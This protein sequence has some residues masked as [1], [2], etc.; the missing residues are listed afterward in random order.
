[1]T[2]ARGTGAAAP[3]VT[4]SRMKEC[5]HP[6]PGPGP[7]K[8]KY[9]GLKR[10]AVGVRSTPLR[11]GGATPHAAILY[12]VK[13][14]TWVFEMKSHEELADGIGKEDYLWVEPAIPPERLMLVVRRLKLVYGAHKQKKVPYG[15]RYETSA[16]DENGGFRLGTGEIGFTCATIVAAIFAAERLRLI[17]PTQWPAPDGFDQD[18][19]RK[20]IDSIRA[21]FPDHAK[22]LDRDITAPRISPEEVA[23]AAAGYPGVGTFDNLQV[24]AAHVR[25]RLKT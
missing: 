22:A 12:K 14:D 2:A 5:L 1:M 19:R 3:E 16:F 13:Q 17:D 18:T 20:F 8:T 15:F 4:A 25:G 24:G 6:I 11:T 9:A 7:A 23:T 10:V 21:K